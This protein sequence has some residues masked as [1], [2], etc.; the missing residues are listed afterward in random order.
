M[1][2]YTSIES[3]LIALG[4]LPEAAEA[5]AILRCALAQRKPPPMENIG[6]YTVPYWVRNE[7]GDK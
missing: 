7:G 5:I 4:D 6:Q 2:P 3:A 1:N